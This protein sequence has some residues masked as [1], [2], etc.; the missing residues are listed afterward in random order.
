MHKFNEISA[1]RT[2]DIGKENVEKHTNVINCAPARLQP[3]IDISKF[4]T[5]YASVVT[6]S[7]ILR[8]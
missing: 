5:Y 6:V 7:P 2:Y 4:A 1:R 8:V 3:H